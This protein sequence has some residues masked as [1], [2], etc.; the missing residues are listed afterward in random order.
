[1]ISQG[2]LPKKSHAPAMPRA[3]AKGRDFDTMR[4]SLQVS[5]W[6]TVGVNPIITHIVLAR[7]YNVNII[8]WLIYIYIYIGIS[9]YIMLY[10]V[11]WLIY[12]Q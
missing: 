7:L 11:I 12:T 4:S 1:M 5:I 9:R 6:H 10:D 2:F 8:E 3:C